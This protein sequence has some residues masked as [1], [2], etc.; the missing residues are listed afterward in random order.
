MNAYKQ[1]ACGALLGLCAPLWLGPE[2][3]AAKKTI[4]KVTYDSGT[5]STKPD[6]I[7]SSLKLKKIFLFPA[8]DDMSGVLAPKLDEKMVQLF[9]RNPRFDL[10]RDNE[11]VKALSPEKASYAAAA[12]APEV[13][14][15]AA[16]V[17]GSDTTALLKTR[18]VG[19]Q[20]EMTLELRDAQGDL[21]FSESGS[22]PGFS[23]MEARWGLIEKL[24]QTTLQKIPFDGTVTGRTAGTVTIDLGAGGVKRGED[25]D[26]VRIVSVQRHP[27]L[28][29]IVG[30]DYVRVGRARVATVDNAISFAEVTEEFPGEL[31]SPG[32][33]VLRTGATTIRRP[34]PMEPAEPGMPRRARTEEPTEEADPFEERLKGEFD[35]SKPR[36]GQVGGNLM[37]G[38]LTHSQTA[39]G[40][41]ADYSV[42]G[43]GGNLE[44]EL[45]ITKNWI[46]SLYY[47]F[48][49]ATLS[50]TSGS[51][52]DASWKRAEGFG[53]YRFFPEDLMEGTILTGSLGYQVQDFSIPA[54]SANS[55]SGKRYAG[56]AVKLDGEVLFSDNNKIGIG[57]GFQPFSS[58]TD[59]GASLGS[60]DSGTV[61]ALQVSWNH[62]L[63]DLF[64]LKV[65]MQFDSASGSYANG[66]SVSDKRF[67]IGPGITYSF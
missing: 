12:A 56:L 19:S 34:E 41:T 28:K 13:H 39:S 44:G 24:F 60:P 4:N 55:L 31:I 50:G 57:V 58:L 37:S 18:N 52:G 14:K 36:F 29:T 42:G 30:T 59:S 22:I 53:G 6:T 62:R 7:D 9:R 51:A 48:H 25:V 5:K 54:N 21:L 45:W 61:I 66:A 33:K 2:A 1:A 63:S 27:L 17:T 47:G 16:R 46:F 15:E 67:A 8:L 26:L 40:T 43:L 3:L 49:N 65:G 23:A 10:V 32:V 38:S 35:R 11:V 64:W 20:T